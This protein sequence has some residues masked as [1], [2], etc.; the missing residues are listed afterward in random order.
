MPD[1][2]DDVRVKKVTFEALRAFLVNQ[3]VE[4]KVSAHI[5][6]ISLALS[7]P[8]FA[9]QGGPPLHLARAGLRRAEH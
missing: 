6:P 9:R 2:L 1:L 7:P 3:G 5:L 8:L 4:E